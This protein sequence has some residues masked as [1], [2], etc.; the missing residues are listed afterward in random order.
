MS[1]TVIQQAA[2]RP[3]LDG[4]RPVH[5]VIAH[6]EGHIEQ[7]C[8]EQDDAKFFMRGAE[9]DLA[10][11]HAMQ[12]AE[13]MLVKAATDSDSTQAMA[14]MRHAGHMAARLS[15]EQRERALRLID[16]IIPE[17]RRCYQYG[18]QQYADGAR[19]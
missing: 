9:A 16:V 1:T 19:A 7:L 3:N 13:L 8:A 17:V 12:R 4:G 6:L 2:A 5:P 14:V 11:A 18:E 10:I 15:K